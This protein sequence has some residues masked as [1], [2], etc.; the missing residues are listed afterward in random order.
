MAEQKE[1]TDINDLA[2]QTQSLFD[3]T[4]AALPRFEQL[5][6]VQESMFK[7][8]ET[9]ARHWLERR[10]EAADTAVEA[11]REMSA[12]DKADP[13]DAMRAIAD[14]QRGSF[15]RL[16]ADMQEWMTLCMQVTH[17]ATTAQ[18]EAAQ[19]GTDQGKSTRTRGRAAPDTKPE[20]AT[21][22]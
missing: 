1:Q 14:W 5:L 22:V 20:H 16:N 21:P 8:A 12:A 10:R 9:F 15:K 18:G 2:R 11:M 7:N 19:A 3:L 4:G 6:E 17:L 13:A